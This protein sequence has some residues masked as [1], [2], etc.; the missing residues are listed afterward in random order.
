MNS[1]LPDRQGA[2][3]L[4]AL[5]LTD[6]ANSPEAVVVALPRGGVPVA[7]EIS[8]SL[9]LP[10]DICLVRKLGVP[11]QPELAM[12]AIAT[13]G[14]QILNQSVINACAVTPVALQSVIDSETLELQRRQQ[15]YLGDRPIYAL[16]NQ[17]VILVDDGIA[18]GSTIL[19]AL[20]GIEAQNPRT[21]IIAVP[22]VAARIYEQ[23]LVYPVAQIVYLLKPLDLHSISTYYENFTQVSDEQVRSLLSLS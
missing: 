4:L 3:K 17:T 5:K 6:Y 12:G 14:V 15:L 7:F 21:I 10:L 13:G 23:L 20:E 16:N 19:A 2:G 18:T 1:I 11:N 9:N 8:Q 22:V